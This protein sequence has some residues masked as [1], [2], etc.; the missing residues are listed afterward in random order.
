MKKNNTDQN[1]NQNNG[2]KWLVKAKEIGDKILKVG[3]QHKKYVA[4]GCLMVG[5]VLILVFA[6][7]S[8]GTPTSDGREI[9]EVQKNQETKVNKL[10][11]AYYS[12]YQKADFTTLKSYATPIS[13]NEAAYIAL[14]SKHVTKYELKEYYTKE[15]KEKD[16][17]LVSA[18]INITFKDV[19]QK[20]PGLDFL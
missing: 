18:R 12:S 1:I 13:D 9:A 11:K 8:K 14:F 10:L 17:F 19:K 15:L 16:A 7:G 3:I 5:F 6:T 20:A 4:A 2:N